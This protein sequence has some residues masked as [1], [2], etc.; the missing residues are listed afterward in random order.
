MGQ[1]RFGQG[2]S[3]EERHVILSTIAFT[4]E[5]QASYLSADRLKYYH[6]AFPALE[7]ALQRTW[8]SS[9]NLLLKVFDPTIIEREKKDLE[10]LLKKIESMNKSRST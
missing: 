10:K 7:G 8:E 6:H 1:R 5:K 2:I 9:K 3:E 4:E